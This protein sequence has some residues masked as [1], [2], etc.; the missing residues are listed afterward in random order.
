[1]HGEEGGWPCLEE[2]GGG[3]GYRYCNVETRR[4]NSGRGVPTQVRRHDRCGP[5]EAQASASYLE[6]VGEEERCCDDDAESFA[7][8]NI[9]LAAGGDSNYAIITV[10]DQNVGEDYTRDDERSET[11]GIIDRRETESSNEDIDKSTIMDDSSSLS[12]SSTYPHD[13]ESEAR[14]EYDREPSLIVMTT[15]SLCGAR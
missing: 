15:A 12:S 11:N 4:K 8:N 13:D 9:R 10:L 1:M 3:K 14:E 5:S 7:D 6:K 2:G